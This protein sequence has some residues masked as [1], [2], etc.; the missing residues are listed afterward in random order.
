MV[1]RRTKSTLRDLA[2]RPPARDL[3]ATWR[4]SVEESDVLSEKKAG[5]VFPLPA[6]EEPQIF[7]K[8]Q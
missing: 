8:Y 3:V 4:M 2:K 7:S 5:W 1:K 6:S